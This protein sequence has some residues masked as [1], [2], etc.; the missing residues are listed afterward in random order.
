MKPRWS[1]KVGRLPAAVRDALSLERGE[2]VLAHATTR[3][4]SY[5]A[6]TGTALYL[7]TPEAGFVRLPWERIEQA[8]WKDGW[9]HI[10]EVGGGDRHHVGLAEPG[11]VPE[12][13]HE[14]VTA[15]IVVSQYDTLPGGGG[16]RIVGRRGQEGG[17]T[18]WTF[19]FDS[20]LDPADPGLRAQA[21]QLLEDLRRQTGL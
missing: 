17:E 9:L 3:G 1:F 18:R 14:R 21:E 20:G 10:R 5:A 12:T 19:V 6:V 16:V 7:P 13:V 2:R 8:Q 4:G 15:T 11:A